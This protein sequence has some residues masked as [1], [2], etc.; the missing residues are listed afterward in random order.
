M[1]PG[2]SPRPGRYVQTVHDPPHVPIPASAAD[3]DR[4][5]AAKPS[6]ARGC[7]A[8]P[9]R[10]AEGRRQVQARTIPRSP[11]PG[12][13]RQTAADLCQPRTPG[14]R[15]VPG[16]KLATNGFGP[17]TPCPLTQSAVRL[18]AS[19]GTARISILTLRGSCSCDPRRRSEAMGPY[20]ALISLFVNVVAGDSVGARKDASR[21]PL[22]GSDRERV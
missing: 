20:S 17:R 21:G 12:W 4:E 13:W 10:G 7:A 22:D 16:I 6:R 2:C 9:E 11:P 15:S 19:A 1:R 5:F 14:V 18:P 3:A 8:R